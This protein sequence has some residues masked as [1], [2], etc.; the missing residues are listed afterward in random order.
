MAIIT[1]VYDSNITPYATGNFT[2]GFDDVFHGTIGGGDSQDGI[3]LPVL[4]A[5]TTYTITMTVEDISDFHAMIIINPADFHSIG[6][7]LTDG[8]AHNPGDHLHYTG[9]M[10]ISNLQVDGNTISMDVTPAQTR[11]YSFAPQASG[12]TTEA[13]TISIQEAPLTTEGDDSV[14]GS[15]GADDFNM[16]AGNDTLDAGE[17]NDTANGANG[18]DVLNGAGGNDQLAGD[19]GQD[20]LN[21]GAGD[22]TLQGGRDNDELNGGDDN[23]ELHGGN[24]DDTL[25]GG[26]GADL[27]LGGRDND[28]LNGD[29]GA[30]TLIGGLGDDTITGGADGDVFSF[31]PG[32]GSDVITDFENGVDVID[33][34]AHGVTSLSDFTIFDDGTNTTLTLP[35]GDA[36]VL[37]GIAWS[38][39]N[40]S[41]FVML[42]SAI[43]GTSGDDVL[44]GGT[45]A[46]TLEGGA[47]NDK[48]Y[49]HDGDDDLSGGDGKDT[50]EGGEGNDLLDGGGKNDKLDGGAGEDT[51]YGGNNND[52]LFGG[53]GDDFLSGDQG[54]DN[55][56][57]GTGADGLAGGRGRD[58]LTGGAD[59]DTFIFANNGGNDTITDFEDGLDQIDLSA[60]GALTEFSDL[61]ITQVGG[62]VIIS[63]DGNNDLTLIGVNAADIDASDFIF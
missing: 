37:E 62:N 30:D 5:G 55:L 52:V 11:A 53:S 44:N 42:P 51:L 56:N 1:E 14:T 23:D 57:G 32:D 33:L 22:D 39:L 46:D 12:G 31:A 47:G 43:T 16:L 6:Y 41:D 10:S 2:I 36:I 18:D 3:N 63:L 60:I 40:A 58:V 50:L 59:A 48:L 4:E 20:T 17:G 7:H 19:A 24:Q 38:D 26:A 61:S 49:G 15:S 28:L 9:F 25:N 29:S 34:S 35:S 13:Y 54:N 45:G 21:G 27:L 8:I